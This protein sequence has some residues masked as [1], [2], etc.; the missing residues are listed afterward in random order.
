MFFGHGSKPHGTREV[1]TRAEKL[2]RAR[3]RLLG[4]DFDVVDAPRRL[5]NWHAVIAHPFEMELNR[6]ADGLL[7]R[8]HAR[9]GRDTAGK[10]RHVCG[11]ITAR[12]LD[13]GRVAHEVHLCL[14]PACLRILFGVPGAKSSLSL[15]GSVTRPG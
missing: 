13:H 14:R 10:I 15:P 6:L 5:R 7:G 1:S 9:S 8:F 4:S 12:V 11:K 3:G 2:E